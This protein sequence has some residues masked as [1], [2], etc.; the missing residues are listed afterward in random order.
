MDSLAFMSATATATVPHAVA[1]LEYWKA[2]A[3]GKDG[4]YIRSRITQATERP[5]MSLKSS[6]IKGAELRIALEERLGLAAVLARGEV[7]LAFPFIMGGQVV[8]VE[9]FEIISSPGLMEGWVVGQVEGRRLAFFDVLYSTGRT[10]YVP[11]QTREFV[12]NAM[13]FSLGRVETISMMQESEEPEIF[14]S[15]LRH[16]VHRSGRTP[17]QG[18]YQSPVEGDPQTVTYFGR[19]YTVLPVSLDEKRGKKLSIDLL[20]APEILEPLGSPIHPG[21]EL[22]GVI[23]LQGYLPELL[24]E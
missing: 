20:V 14:M 1:R 7:E 6:I 3:P 13:A 5:R 18:V 12:L 19:A 16:Y 23:W 15:R 2:L 17:D 24:S 21:D 8:P 11:G 10:D 9:I 22:A 4:D